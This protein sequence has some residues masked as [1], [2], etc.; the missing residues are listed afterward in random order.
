MSNYN[1]KDL[2]LEEKI[3]QLIVFG[4]DALDVNDHA[5]NLI[6]KYKAGNVILFARNVETPEQVFTL[7]QNLQKLALENLGIPL[8]I[9]IDQE[10][11][12]VTRIKNGGTF[13]PGAMTLGATKTVKNSYLSG[14]YMGKELISLGINMNLAPVLDVNNNPY[15]PVIGVRSYSDNVTAVSDHGFA[16]I[17]GLQENVIATAKHFPGHGDTTVDSHLSL[18]KINK[19][20]EEISEL[21]LI[22]FKNSIENGLRAIMSSHI[23]FPAITNGL[24]TT[25]SKKA[26][27]GLLR[28]EM[29]FKGLIIS[30]CMQMKAIQKDY[31]TPSGVKMAIEAG[32]N[33]ACISH[34]EELQTAS[35]DALVEAVK[36]NEISIDTINQRVSKVLDYKRK[37][38]KP[39]LEVTYEN[40]RK[41]I[42]DKNTKEFALNVVREGLTLIKGNNIVL[43]KKSILIA[44]EPLSTTIADEDDGSYSIIQSVKNEIPSLDT[45]VVS[46]RLSD[47][48]VK[49]V[50]DKAKGYEQVI[51]CSYN[52]NIYQKQIELIDLLE[53]SSNLTV[54]MMRNPYDSVFASKI[55]NLLAMYEYTPNSVKVLMEYLQG[56]IVPIGKIP[57][58]I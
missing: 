20:L 10:G 24:P 17:K 37:Y 34:S 14:K 44:S 29:N 54:V 31:G 38:I 36:S 9:S 15:N 51:F 19:T 4:F 18:P 7:N 26:L 45:M 5:L 13:F 47:E 48:E 30:D 12:M 43:D 49:S 23:N 16:F 21:E 56:K 41:I 33:L 32:V 50:L 22:P 40:I 55:S 52:A 27:T 28:E 8:I 46:V 57:V 39:N 3:G 2:T 58:T 25:L 53:G 1:I 35:I 42:E 6:T 11:G